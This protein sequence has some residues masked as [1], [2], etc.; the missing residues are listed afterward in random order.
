HSCISNVSGG[1]NNIKNLHRNITSQIHL[2]KKQKLLEFFRLKDL[3]P[4]MKSKPG[5]I[6]LKDLTLLQNIES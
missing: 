3:S 6:R 5:N 2:N 1:D 4:K